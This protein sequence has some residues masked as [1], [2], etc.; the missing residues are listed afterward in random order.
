MTEEQVKQGILS[1]LEKKG[2]RASQYL[3]LVD[4]Y[5]AMW[6]IKN[7]L[8]ADI[9]ERGVSIEWQN[10]PNQRGY[11]KNDSLPELN[12]VSAS[13]LKILSDLG[14]RGADFEPIQEKP[15]L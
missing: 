3:S 2:L 11:R 5:M 1:E 10:G 15:T 13:M 14:L 9:E 7:D 8:I 6:R 4:D 12:R